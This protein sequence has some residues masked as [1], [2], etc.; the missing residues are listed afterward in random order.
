MATIFIRIERV[1]LGTPLD[2]PPALNI[3]FQPKLKQLAPNTVLPA[4]ELL[5]HATRRLA[6]SLGNLSLVVGLTHG[7]TWRGVWGGV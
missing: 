2:H 1:E 7:R 5:S 4:R 6:E 3:R